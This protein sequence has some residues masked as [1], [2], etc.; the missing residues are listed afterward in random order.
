MRADPLSPAA[1]AQVALPAPVNTLV[2]GRAT[3]DTLHCSAWLDL[4]AGPIVLSVPDTWG[5]YCALWLRDA[6]GR[7]F[8]S[9]GART[10]GTA[11]RDFVV[12]GPGRHSAG[13]PA[14]VHADPG[15]DAHRRARRAPR[16]RR[17]DRRGGDPQRHEGFRLSG[18]RV[19]APAVPAPAASRSVRTGPVNG[20]TRAGDDPAADV[21]HLRT[22]TDADARPLSG[23]QRYACVRPDAAP[24]VNGFWELTAG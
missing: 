3:P 15:S 20:W 10:T 23:A 12:L 4:T 19:L 13:A 6:R 8:A 18:A 21:L 16:S 24:P 1:I 5:R 11:R 2:C 9:I 14:G 17:R 22:D 7:V